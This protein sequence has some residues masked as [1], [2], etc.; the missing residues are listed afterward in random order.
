MSTPISRLF[1]PKTPS[2]HRKLNL[3]ANGNNYP[4]YI[5]YQTGTANLFPVTI[6]L[7]WMYSNSGN[8]VTANS[9]DLYDGNRFGNCETTL[10]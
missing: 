6:V 5:G 10:Y 8:P 2:A 9:C 1:L 4:F 3:I 7:D